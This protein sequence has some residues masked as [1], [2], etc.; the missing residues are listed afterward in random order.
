M[1]KQAAATS[2]VDEM[3]PQDAFNAIQADP[4]AVMVDVRTQAEWRLVGM[5][6]L[7]SVGRDVWPIEWVMLPSM[8]R[9][10]DFWEALL[11]HGRGGVPERLFLICKSGSRSLAAAH[12]IAAEAERAGRNVH[13]TNVA[14]GFEGYSAPGGH[15]GGL[16]G[17][18]ARGLPWQQN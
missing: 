6:D 13:C 14:E 11:Q 10:P 9:N 16:S 18:K 1:G 4:S 12:Y 15:Q 2:T 5:P 7:S 8:Q 3:S 17:W